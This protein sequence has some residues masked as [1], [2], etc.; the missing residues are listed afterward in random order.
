MVEIWE[1]QVLEPHKDRATLEGDNQMSEAVMLMHKTAIK[2]NSL[3]SHSISVNEIQT[4]DSAWSH[5]SGH[6]EEQKKS[7]DKRTK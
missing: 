1:A 7:V 5:R 2:K 4:S 6:R 3:E